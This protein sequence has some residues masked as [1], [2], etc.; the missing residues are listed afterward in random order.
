[1]HP[2]TENACPPSVQQSIFISENSRI[3]LNDLDTGEAFTFTLVLPEYVNTKESK[4]SVLTP[5]GAV[6]L[7]HRVGDVVTWK[8]PSRLRRFEIQSFSHST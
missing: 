7:G 4:I 5:L 6:L 3:R 8:A 2:K 1:M